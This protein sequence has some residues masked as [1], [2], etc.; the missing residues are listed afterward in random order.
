MQRTAMR[1]KWSNVDDKLQS[2]YLGVLNPLKLTLMS[3]R[4]FGDGFAMKKSMIV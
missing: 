1:L 4:G 3:Q 2:L